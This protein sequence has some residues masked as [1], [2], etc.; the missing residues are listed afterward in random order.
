MA[1]PGRERGG[2]DARSPPEHAQC[3]CLLVR[4]GVRDPVSRVWRV[5]LIVIYPRVSGPA[6][7]TRLPKPPKTL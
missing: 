3:G 5:C 1:R 4:G 6:R 7:L 2:D